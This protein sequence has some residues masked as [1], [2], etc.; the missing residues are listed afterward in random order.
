MC[1]SLD[2]KSVVNFC[3]CELTVHK[4]DEEMPV[5]KFW[6]N[7]CVK[8]AKCSQYVNIL[9]Q[10]FHWCKKLNMDPKII[11]EPT[12]HLPQQN[13][14]PLCVSWLMKF[15]LLKQHLKNVYNREDMD[16]FLKKKYTIPDI[17]FSTFSLKLLSHLIYLLPK[18]LLYLRVVLN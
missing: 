18:S 2:L 10:A 11:N 5:S 14:F 12:R 6:I 13:D 4:G 7:C 8:Y 16:G 1:S 3:I 17:C 15:S 9:Q